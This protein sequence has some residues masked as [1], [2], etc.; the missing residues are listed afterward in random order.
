MPDSMAA[1][2][3]HALAG[4]PRLS[5][6]NFLAVVGSV[7][8]K[9]Y[10]D[11][12]LSVSIVSNYV[13]VDGSSLAEDEVVK[14][15]CV[16]AAPPALPATARRLNHL[17]ADDCDSS[18]DAIRSGLTD[19]E[20]AAFSQAI[21]I[22]C[23]Y[24]SLLGPECARA[25]YYDPSEVGGDGFGVGEAVWEGGVAFRPRSK[26]RAPAVRRSSRSRRS[27]RFRGPAPTA[28]GRATTA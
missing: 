4:S 1:F 20:Y 5:A 8:L 16:A 21:G 13:P 12:G 24:R 25:Y 3:L 6:A 23:S 18:D 26:S 9:I 27:R 14:A 19:E 2:S 17:G 11:I 10:S 28:R 7:A 22:K 15:V